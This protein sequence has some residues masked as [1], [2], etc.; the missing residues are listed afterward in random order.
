MTRNDH[1]IYDFMR[2]FVITFFGLDFSD[3]SSLLFRCLRHSFPGDSSEW[4]IFQA[5]IH[6]AHC[7]HW[8]VFIIFF[9]GCSGQLVVGSTT[10]FVLWPQLILDHLPRYHQYL[11]FL[12]RCFEPLLRWRFWIQGVCRSNKLLLVQWT[13]ICYFIRVQ[14]LW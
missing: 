13:Y 1:E 4:P 5:T 8:Q 14:W 6:R 11:R 9:I 2:A 10:N 3:P 7:L 12:L